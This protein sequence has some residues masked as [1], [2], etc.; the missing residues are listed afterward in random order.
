MTQDG[1]VAV[2]RGEVEQDD[3]PGPRVLEHPVL[4]D[5]LLAELPD[6]LLGLCPGGECGVLGAAVGGVQVELV[7]HQWSGALVETLRHRERLSNG[8]LLSSLI[9]LVMSDSSEESQI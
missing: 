7:Q 3:V 4:T 1:L 5:P 8:I 6:L 2:P 9:P